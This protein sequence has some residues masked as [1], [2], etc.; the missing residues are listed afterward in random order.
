LSAI[1]HGGNS[2]K[3]Q[4]AAVLSSL[5]PL[6]YKV[7]PPLIGAKPISSDALAL[8]AR[9]YT[10]AYK[11]LSI[12]DW[13]SYVVF[14]IQQFASPSKYLTT[15]DSESTNERNLRLGRY[16]RLHLEN[17]AP[18]DKALMSQI[19]GIEAALHTSFPGYFDMSIVEMD[20]YIMS[21]D[22]TDLHAH[23]TSLNVLL[24]LD[25][26]NSQQQ[27]T[28]MPNASSPNTSPNRRNDVPSF[29]VSGPVEENTQH[30]TQSES[31][32]TRDID[33][34]RRS[35]L[36]KKVVFKNKTSDSSIMLEATPNAQAPAVSTASDDQF[37]F[38]QPLPSVSSPTRKSLKIPT[39]VVNSIRV[40]VR[41]APKD[42][43]E[44][45]ASTAQLYLRLA[46]ILSVFNS[47]YSWMIEWQTDQLVTSQILEPAS[48]TKF[49][50]IRVMPSVQQQCF[51][52]SFR[53]NATGSQFTQVVQ[54]R[55]FDPSFIPTNQGEITNVG[56]ILLKD[57]TTTHRSQYLQYLRTEVLPPDMPAF[58]LKLRHKDPSGVKTQILTVRCGRQVATQVAQSLSAALNGEGSNPEIFISRLA[59]G[60]NRIA[61]GDHEA[62]YKVHHE[63]MSDIVYLPFPVNQKIDSEIVEYLETGDQI[64]RTP[65]QSYFS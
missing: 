57:A 41:W 23:D 61:R 11:T 42:F 28:A 2:L 38:L 52:F 37:S 44:L 47:S 53:V 14:G 58:D 50:S 36:K 12:K 55:Q 20:E 15:R 51:Y 54:S 56:D 16:Y 18:V 29:W 31:P 33:N 59:L 49:L 45:K 25:T 17:Q 3:P 26:T 4:I 27:D 35:P 62:I 7:P 10:K 13:N 19:V 63:Y 65:R 46:P 32:S 40:E 24:P 5:P 22:P 9:N 34:K 48:L 1:H 8:R 21:L 6:G 60:A 30:P 39:I 64:S 43:K